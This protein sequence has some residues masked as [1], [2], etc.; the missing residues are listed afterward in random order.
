MIQKAAGKGSLKNSS[1]SEED[2]A[3]RLR[4]ASRGTSGGGGLPAKVVPRDTGKIL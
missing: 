2:L 4:K 1:S 3:Y